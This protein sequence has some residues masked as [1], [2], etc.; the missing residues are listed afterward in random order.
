MTVPAHLSLTQSQAFT[1]L[2]GF[3][4]SILPA[5]VGVIQGQANRV[6]EPGVPNF[7]VMTALR[8]DRLGFNE[9]DYNDTIFVGSIAATEL[10]VAS[11]TQ[12]E[13]SGILAGMTIIDTANPTNL[14][15]DT[16]VVEQLSGPPGGAG[17][18]TISPTQTVA[19]ETMY[20]GQ[21]AALVPTRWTVQLDIHGPASGDNAKVIEGL[22]RSE[23]AIGS[24]I[25][26]GF[27]VAP[28][29]CDEAMQ[30]PFINGEDQYEDRYVM[31]ACMQINPIIGTPQQFAEEL[32][33]AV[34]DVEEAYPLP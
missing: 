10:T 27:D 7:V 5:A 3:I 22:F 11:V 30:L 1:A 34:I 4:T 12:F 19:S 26:S 2:G 25:A 32:D 33:P 29:Y 15:A 13:G 6:A 31:S 14:A 23:V 18:Y 24:F 9:A 20:A 21:S 16:V 17:V 8:Q 28:L